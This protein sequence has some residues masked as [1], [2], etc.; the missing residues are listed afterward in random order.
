[1]VNRA[2]AR[3]PNGEAA[4]KRE[5]TRRDAAAFDAMPRPKTPPPLP[6]F[7]PRARTAGELALAEDKRKGVISGLAFR[8][9]EI[10]E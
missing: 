1:V 10:G 3:F 4:A 5:A 6:A 2:F 8:V 9:E 7:Q